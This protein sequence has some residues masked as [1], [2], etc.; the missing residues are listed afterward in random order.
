MII[1][2]S[3]YCRGYQCPKMLWMD[4]HKPQEAK[5]MLDDSVFRTGN[6]VG[7]LA[8]CYFGQY[9]TVGLDCDKY[10]M[11]ENTRKYIDPSYEYS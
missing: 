2:K 3:K 7:E 4:E 6:E 11:V 1:S 10:M 5:K 8:R 9:V